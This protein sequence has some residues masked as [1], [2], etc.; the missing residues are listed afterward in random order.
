METKNPTIEQLLAEG[1]ARIRRIHGD[2]VYVGSL[3][4]AFVK[5][6]VARANP[7]EAEKKA[8]PAKKAKG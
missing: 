4:D 6:I 3:L 5:E 1:H 2:L 7:P 8:E